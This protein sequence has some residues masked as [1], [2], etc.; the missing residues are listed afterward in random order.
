MNAE[1]DALL[2]RY[3]TTIPRAPRI[4]ALRQVVHHM[5]DQLN[6]MTL[7]YRASPTMVSN[8]LRNVGPDPTWNAQDWTLVG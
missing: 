5:T 3:L 7:Y 1:F 6:I 4:D 8:R 2:D